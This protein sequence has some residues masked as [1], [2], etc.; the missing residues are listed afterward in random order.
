MP[1]DLPTMVSGSKFRGEFEERLKSVID[2]VE[3]ADGEIILF[4]GELHTMVGASN[5]EGGVDA[6][7]M[8]KPALSRGEM[9]CIGATALNED[10]K[11]IEK[12]SAPE[13]R[14]Q[15]IFLEEPSVKET[16]EI[17]K[18]FCPRSEAHHKVDISDEALVAAARL[19]DRY[20]T[21]R[22]L[23]DRT[24]NFIDEACGKLRINAQVL[25]ASFKEREESIR[26]LTDQETAA[27]ERSDYLHAAE[28]RTER[29]LLK[30]EYD[31]DRQTQQDD[32]RTEK[33]VDEGL[34]AQLV[35]EWTGILVGRLYGGRGR[36]YGTHGDRPASPH[37]RVG[38]GCH[39][40]L[41]GHP[42]ITLRTQ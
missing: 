26:R 30:Q 23:P 40:C 41:Q 19:I 7:N 33:V 18:I 13:R 42:A 22:Q 15:P 37:H 36:A 25:S 11:F 29:L 31:A 5:S 39:G 20:I 17:L 21:G 6:S 8:L 34:I 1:L 28:L 32:R 27:A 4:L 38:R 24:V 10:R 14:F 12:D 2:E 16:V 3:E 9:Q 35:S